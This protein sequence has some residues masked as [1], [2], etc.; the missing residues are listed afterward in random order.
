MTVTVEICVEDTPGALGAVAAGA[1]RLEVCSDLSCGGLTPPAGLIEAALEAAPP[2]G[3]QVLIRERAGDFVYSSAEIESMARS[4]E[5]MRARAGDARLGFV[6]GALTRGGSVDVRAAQRWREAAGDAR[7]T[8]HRAIDAARD[9]HDAVETVADLGFDLILTTGGAPSVADTQGLR[10]MQ[11]IAGE[12]LAILGSGGVRAANV[13]QVVS[14][15]GLREIHMRAPFSHRGDDAGGGR[16]SSTDRAE[17]AR[18][19]DTL[20]RAGLR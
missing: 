1:D 4:I 9:P 20:Q 13:A 19:V 6:V 5:Q 10:A 7:L 8:F 12:R 15:A 11:G 16:E 3:V 2:D 18:I 14:E 17:V